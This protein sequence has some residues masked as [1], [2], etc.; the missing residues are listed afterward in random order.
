MSF[1]AL[2]PASLAAIQVRI[3]PV[4]SVYISDQSDQ[5]AL[6]NHLDSMSVLLKSSDIG[7][8]IFATTCS[9]CHANGVAGAPKYHDMNAWRPRLAKGLST[10]LEHVKEGYNAM[11]PRG[12][13]VECTDADLRKAIEFM[14]AS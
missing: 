2:D 9:T 12:T 6:Q 5:S 4:G 1:A 10:L 11:P 14:T 8:R 3:Q 7:A 13:C